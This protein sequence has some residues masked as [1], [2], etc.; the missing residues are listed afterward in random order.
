MAESGSWFFSLSC[1]LSCYAGLMWKAVWLT[2]PYAA[3][4]ICKSS[5]N[6]YAVQIFY[7]FLSLFVHPHVLSCHSHFSG[8]SASD[9]PVIWKPPLALHPLLSHMSPCRPINHTFTPF[10]ASGQEGLSPPHSAPSQD[11]RHESLTVSSAF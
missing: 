10:T 3:Q 6:L 5:Q 9:A 4:R 11:S 8:L 7:A 1:L 2:L